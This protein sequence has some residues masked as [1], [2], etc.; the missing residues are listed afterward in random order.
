MK[1]KNALLS[2]AGVAC[3]A[4]SGQTAEA[5]DCAEGVDTSLGLAAT[6]SG[7]VPDGGFVSAGFSI[8]QSMLCEATPQLTAEDVIDLIRDELDDQAIAEAEGHLE[9]AGQNLHLLGLRLGGGDP[10][11]DGV[12][13]ESMDL[14]QAILL[15]VDLAAIR[16]DIRAAEIGFHTPLTA[17][18]NRTR[19]DLSIA[20]ILAHYNLTLAKLA[21]A[22]SDGII[23]RT[24]AENVANDILADVADYKEESNRL[25]GISIDIMER[26]NDS[27]GVRFMRSGR[28]MTPKRTFECIGCY[29]Q[30]EHPQQPALQN[31]LLAILKAETETLFAELDVQDDRLAVLESRAQALL[32]DPFSFAPLVTATGDTPVLLKNAHPNAKNRCLFNRAGHLDRDSNL[33]PGATRMRGCN[34]ALSH[35]GWILEE[36]GHVRSSIANLCLTAKPDKKVLTEECS[37]AQDVELDDRQTW[38]RD[39]N[40]F[41]VEIDGQ[42]TCLTPG[43]G[44]TNSPDIVARHIPCEDSILQQQWLAFSQLRNGRAPQ[45]PGPSEE[46]PTPEELEAIVDELN[47]DADNALCL[48]AS[49]ELRPC[50]RLDAEMLWAEDAQGRL[51]PFDLD[52]RPL[53]FHPEIDDLVSTDF[54]LSRPQQALQNVT[55]LPLFRLQA[56]DGS[57]TFVRLDTGE[58]LFPG[59]QESQAQIFT[60]PVVPDVE[61]NLDNSVFWRHFNGGRFAE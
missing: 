41:R 5:A 42:Q 52:S 4:L 61:G 47:A 25:R 14:A 50:D 10:Q 49:S 29:A 36:S 22:V 48:H 35:Q 6:I 26:D 7:L 38:F 18:N 15:I 56:P 31:R 16:S 44:G 32:D 13:L 54:G 46:L 33:K 11:F 37:D 1:I 9:L 12:R 51:Q 3:V 60:G 53:S 21:T 39:G 2:L 8:F 30:G 34:P 24:F 23:A 40:T 59:V 17:R 45:L 19:Y 58:L 20:I 57:S 43:K 55:E 28:A 27:I